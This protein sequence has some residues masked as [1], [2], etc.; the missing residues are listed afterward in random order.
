MNVLVIGHLCLDVIH[1]A[2]GPET[3]SYGGIY[4]ALTT[5]SSVLEKSD[6]IIP[7]FG[8]HKQDY[9]PLVERL[10][11]F[12]NIDCSAIFKFDEPTNTVHLYYGNDAT[13]RECSRNIAQPIPYSR[14]H[15]HLSVDGVL[16]NMISGVDIELETLDQIRMAIR[17]RQIPIHLD[18]HS[19]TLGITG[20]DERYRRP[21]EQWRRWAFMVD[22]VQMNEEE[23]L[24]LATHADLNGNRTEE[25]I[26]G[27]LLTLSV[28]AVLVTRG[29]DGATV[30]RNDKKHL[31]RTDIAGIESETISDTTGCGDIFGAAFFTRYLQSRDVIKAAEFAN[32]IAAQKVGAVGSDR[33]H[34]QIS[35]FLAA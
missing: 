27:H 30:Y 34:E 20:N 3:H 14:I 7:V 25:Q 4:Y 22:T 1:P 15:R 26:A 8:V 33:L 29:A 13:R 19:L 28:K 2:S 9:S 35:G 18:I 24:S 17:S 16:V 32:R 11:G 31:A 10:H 23:I 6:R 21:V 5:L 12:G